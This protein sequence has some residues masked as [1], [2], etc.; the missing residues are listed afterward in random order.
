MHIICH[1][2]RIFPKAKWTVP[3]S[4]KVRCKRE[5]EFLFKRKKGVKEVTIVICKSSWKA[6]YSRNRHS[7]IDQC[8]NDQPLKIWEISRNNQHSKQV[9]NESVH[10][11]ESVCLKEVH[12]MFNKNNLRKWVNILLPPIIHHIPYFLDIRK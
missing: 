4:T 8:Y 9:C 11:W 10:V 6:L 3:L 2:L 5:R 1:W 12:I 7:D